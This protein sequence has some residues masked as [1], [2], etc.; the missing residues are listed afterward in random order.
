MNI[1]YCRGSKETVACCTVSLSSAQD[2]CVLCSDLSSSPNV[3]PGICSRLQAFAPTVVLT[4]AS[5]PQS[6][7]SIVLPVALTSCLTQPH[8]LWVTFSCLLLSLP[9]QVQLWSQPDFLGL[10]LPPAICQ[11]V[12]SGIIS[13][14]SFCICKMGMIPAV[15]RIK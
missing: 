3:S 13:R 2:T 5:L 9:G 12:K 7:H 6:R 11:R 14:L 15:K 10:S 1:D 4:P 8:S